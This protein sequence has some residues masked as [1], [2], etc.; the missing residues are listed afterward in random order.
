[1]SGINWGDVPTWLAV[2]VATIGGYAA[3]RQLRM[4][5][6]DMRRQI[7]QLERQQAQQIAVKAQQVQVQ[8]QDGD[9]PSWVLMAV[10]EN[11]SA[12]PIRNVDCTAAPLLSREDAVKPRTVGE[13]IPAGTPPGTDVF[14][15]PQPAEFVSVIRGGQ[16][17]GFQFDLPWDRHKG[18]WLLFEFEDDAGLRWILDNE[19]HLQFSP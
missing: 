11:G 18:D 16:K 3:L 8:N 4:Q 13:L 9:G 1:M 10:V 5:Q 6:D 14:S 7:A 12:R 15:E 19:M 2:V 17:F